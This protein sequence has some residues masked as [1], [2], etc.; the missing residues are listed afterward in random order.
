LRALFTFAHFH[1]PIRLLFGKSYE[2]G[3]VPR[4]YV[5]TYLAIKLPLTIL[6]GAVLGLMLSL[7][8]ARAHDERPPA[9]GVNH[10]DRDHHR[11]PGDVQVIVNGPAFTGLRHFLFVVPPR[12]PRRHRLRRAL[13]CRRAQPRA[14]HWRIRGNRHF[15]RVERGHAGSPASLRIHVLARSSAA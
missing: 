15:V 11:I 13:N 14:G 1:Y 6:F 2:M 7:I 8:G 10:A 3:E 9:A 4:W 5:P 12:R